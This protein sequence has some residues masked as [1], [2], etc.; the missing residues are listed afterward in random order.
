MFIEFT[1][2]INCAWYTQFYRSMLRGVLCLGWGGAGLGASEQ[3]IVDPVK[4]AEVRGASDMYRGI[5]VDINDPYE[6]F[7]KNR[8]GVFIQKLRDRDELLQKMKKNSGKYLTTITQN[9]FFQLSF[10]LYQYFTSSC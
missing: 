1:S 8:A 10:F 2:L 9:I 3:G 5:G 4:A 7:R 6:S